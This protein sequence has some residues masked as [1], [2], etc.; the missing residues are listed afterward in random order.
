M[1]QRPQGPLHHVQI[2][3]LAVLCQ[4]L[5]EQVPAR[6]AVATAVCG[7]SEDVQCVGRAPSVADPPGNCQA[8]GSERVGSPII[9][10]FERYQPNAMRQ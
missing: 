6:R 3:V 10:D 2:G 9:V 8:F 7:P 1:P 4:T 5:L